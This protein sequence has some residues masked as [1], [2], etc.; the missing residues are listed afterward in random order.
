MPSYPAFDIELNRGS[1]NLTLNPS[2]TSVL[3]VSREANETTNLR[4]AIKPQVENRDEAQRLS[5]IPKPSKAVHFDGA[6]EYIEDNSD[7]TP[8]VGTR[9]KYVGIRSTIFYSMSDSAENISDQLQSDTIVRQTPR[10]RRSG[11]PMEFCDD[12]KTGSST[13]GFDGSSSA[14]SLSQRSTG[15]TSL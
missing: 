1:D 13:P 11:L 9:S 15:R 5:E 3:P 7:L 4:S 2:A 12:S 10:R 14:S 8:S 6:S